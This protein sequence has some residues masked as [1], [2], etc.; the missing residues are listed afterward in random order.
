MRHPLWILNSTLLSLCIATLFFI[1]LSR[2]NIPEDEN[3]EPTTTPKAVEKQASEINIKKIYEYDLFGTYRKEPVETKQPDYLQP[4]P[5]PPQPRALQI[6]EEPKPQFIDP[7]KIS[8]RGI[9]Y[10]VNDYTKNRAIIADSVT[11][12][13]SIYKV[14]DIIEDAQLIKIF[15]KKVVFLR[16]NGQQEVIYL[17]EQDAKLDQEYIAIGDWKEVVQ[18]LSD[19]VYVINKNKFTQRVRTVAQ[20]IELFDL[21][22]VYKKGVSIGCRIGASGQATI[23]QSFGFSPE[24]IIISVNNIPATDTPNR[25]NIYKNILNLKDNETIIVKVV[26]NNYPVIIQFRFEE[27]KPKITSV[28]QRNTTEISQDKIQ[29]LQQRHSFAPTLREIREQERKNML[30]KGKLS[31]K[32]SPQL[33]E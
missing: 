33:P 15:N 5:T 18:K 16:A 13:E 12:K 32:Q 6:P 7:L 31:P 8:L 24:D 20:F 9:T 10:I 27:P 14:G 23:A 4:L 1:L 21:T 11:S 25:L 30:N 28:Q 29:Q 3:I 2:Q 19:N 22:T 17:R 26:R